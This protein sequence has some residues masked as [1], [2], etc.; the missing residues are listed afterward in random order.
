MHEQEADYPFDGSACAGSE[1][2]QF[3]NT[4]NAIALRTIEGAVQ[5]VRTD[6]LKKPNPVSLPNRDWLM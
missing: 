1:V 5:A 3:E 6:E 4:K 2:T